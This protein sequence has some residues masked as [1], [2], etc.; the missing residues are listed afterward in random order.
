MF[1]AI[2]DWAL[3]FVN[4]GKDTD[5]QLNFTKLT[6]FPEIGPFFFSAL[7]LMFSPAAG[8]I[9]ARHHFWPLVDVANQA[10]I[11]RNTMRIWGGNETRRQS[12]STMMIVDR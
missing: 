3:E 9:S 8:A 2:R 10:E 7:L 12:K 4:L 6:R 5:D 1:F 11:K